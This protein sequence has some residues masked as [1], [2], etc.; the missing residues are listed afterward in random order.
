VFRLE[1][2]RTDH[3]AALLDFELANRTYFAAS[4]PDR[5]DDYFAEFDQ[6]LRDLLTDQAAGELHFHVLVTDDGQIVGRVNLVDVA[7]GS[8]ELGYRIGEGTS[9]QGLATSAVAR[10]CRLAVDEYGLTRLTAATTV[11]NVGSRIVLERNGFKA[12]GEAVFDGRPGI[13]FEKSL[14]GD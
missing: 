7:D 3:A 11:D 1:R 5:G 14:S 10:V 6:R 8:A 12:V 9:G 13:E 4:I 2:L